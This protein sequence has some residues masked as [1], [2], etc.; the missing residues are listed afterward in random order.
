MV[1]IELDPLEFPLETP[2]PT[3]NQFQTP[4]VCVHGGAC[5]C[6]GNASPPPP[7]TKQVLDDFSIL[8]DFDDEAIILTQ[9]MKALIDFGG[10]TFDSDLDD[11]FEDTTRKP[12]RK[13][14]TF[15]VV[16]NA[17]VPSSKPHLLGVDNEKKRTNCHK[18]YNAIEKKRVATKYFCVSCI[19]PLCLQCFINHQYL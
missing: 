10:E 8:E 13:R 1:D 4:P 15:A 3:T 17:K 9:E 19:T 12:K 14:S 11:V 2:R 18:C 7:P 5:S 16:D 6:T